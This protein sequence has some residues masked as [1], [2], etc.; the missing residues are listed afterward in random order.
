MTL[1]EAIHRTDAAKPNVC[2]QEEKI[3]W[4]SILDG[5]VRTEII[6][7]RRGDEGEAFAA[8]GEGTPLTTP[9]L[10]PHPYDEVY[11]RWLEAQIDYA[12]GEYGKYNNS[13]T[14]FNAAFAAFERY[15]NRTHPIASGDFR[16][17]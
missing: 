16:H 3:R 6:G 14:A 7:P 10:I 13:I 1:I 2:A 11:V 9:L 4:L 12:C 5:I 15:Y 17:Y 8:Y